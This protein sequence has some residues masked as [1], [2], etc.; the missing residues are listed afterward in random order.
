MVNDDDSNENTIRIVDRSARSN[1]LDDAGRVFIV[2]SLCI[3]VL[4]GGGGLWVKKTYIYVW[5]AR[6]ENVLSV[7]LEKRA[8]SN[9]EPF[10]WFEIKHSVL[11]IVFKCEVECISLSHLQIGASC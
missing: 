7:Y 2:C 5:F 11:L 1:A 4:G 6:S 8:L 9:K 10:K 3:S